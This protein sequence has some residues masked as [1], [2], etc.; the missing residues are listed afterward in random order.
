MIITISGTAGS[1]KSTL[2]KNLAKKLDATWI[3]IGKMRRDLAKKKGMTIEE[4]N[5]Y[6]KTN[7]ETDVEI[8]EKASKK[9]KSLAKQGKTIIVEGRTQFHF[10]AD[11]IK[12]YI[13]VDPKVAAKRIWEDHKNEEAKNNRNEKTYKTVKALEKSI[14]ERGKNDTKRFKKYYKID[15]TKESNYDLILDT[16]NLSKQ[17]ALKQVLDFIKEHK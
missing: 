14:K 10:L 12:I 3:Y 1:G 11:S 4:L 9:A 6:A 13:K 2:S 5:E 16:G 15:D 8:D 17:E 7:P